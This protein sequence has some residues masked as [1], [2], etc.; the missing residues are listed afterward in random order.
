MRRR[1]I[2][3]TDG[4]EVARKAVEHC[5]YKLGLR[6]ISASAGN[7]TPLTGSD[8]A[9]LALQAPYDPVLV[10]V[11]D[12]GW[13]GKGEGERALEALA[14]DDRLEII[15]AIAVASH[16][17]HGPSTAVDS[18]VAGN[19]KIVDG[20]VDKAGRELPDTREITGDT[21]S[22]LSQLHLP[23]VI[24][25]GDVGKMAGK[26]CIER[27]APRT[28]AAIAEIMRRSGIGVGD[29]GRD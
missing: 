21:V 24:G 1:V 14:G 4:D 12:K 25:L 17:E 15:G 26:D 8:I 27:G 7:P 23:V 10:M 13:A 6:C 19:G 22:I 2:I 18:S 11:D 29:R 5:G 16:T 3:V 20:A 9:E 28:L